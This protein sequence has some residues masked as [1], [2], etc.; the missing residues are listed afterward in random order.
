MRRVAAVKKGK[1]KDVYAKLDK[2]LETPSVRTGGVEAPF[3][4][5]AERLRNTDEEGD[6]QVKIGA[7]GETRHWV[8]GL[9]NRSCKLTQGKVENPRFELLVRAEA[10][11]QILAGQTSPIWTMAKSQMRVRGDLEF[12]K[13]IYRLLAADDGKIDP[14]EREDGA[15]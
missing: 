8:F 11:E 14:C 7:K 3:K 5:I 13:R 15:K 1:P 9:G 10:L 6:V 4:R 2:F 12:G